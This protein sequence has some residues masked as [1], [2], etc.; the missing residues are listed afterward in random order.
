MNLKRR[1]L[2]VRGM[3]KDIPEHLNIDI[4]SLEI[5]Q[6]IKI[7]DLSYDKLDIIDNK[8]AMIVGVA[9]SLMVLKEEEAAPAEGAETPAAE[10]AGAEKE[11]AGK[12]DAGHKDAAHK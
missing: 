4:T 2:K 1:T 10:G 6:S 8:K 3:T 5:G 7:G 9:V 12:K 11:E